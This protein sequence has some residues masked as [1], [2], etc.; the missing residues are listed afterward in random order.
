MCVVAHILA[1]TLATPVKTLPA[2]FNSPRTQVTADATENTFSD[3][4]PESLTVALR[5]VNGKQ[6]VN[7]L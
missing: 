3:I 7:R 5:N 2:D 1:Y 6:L 4:L